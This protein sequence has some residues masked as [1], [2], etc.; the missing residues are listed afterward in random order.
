M[1]AATQD[2]AK[3]I[4]TNPELE[5]KFTDRQLEQIEAGR[6]KIDGY[7]WHHSEEEGTMQLVDSDIHRKTGH[8]GGQVIWGG[9]SQNR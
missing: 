2:L 9:G 8:T 6:P 7:T 3:Q 1:K 5:D 4:E